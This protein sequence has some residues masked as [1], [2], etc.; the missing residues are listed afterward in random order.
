[1]RIPEMIKHLDIPRSS[2]FINRKIERLLNKQGQVEGITIDKNGRY[3]LDLEIIDHHTFQD[4]IQPKPVL[5]GTQAKTYR[6]YQCDTIIFKRL[7]DYN[8]YKLYAHIRPNIPVTYFP[9]WKHKYNNIQSEI[10][11]HYPNGWVK[12]VGVKERSERDEKYNN[13][14]MHVVINSNLDLS[15]LRSII[16]KSFPESLF[17]LKMDRYNSCGDNNH[18]KEHNNIK[19]SLKHGMLTHHQN[20][21]NQSAHT[22]ILDYY[23]QDGKYFYNTYS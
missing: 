15:D 1:M 11:K 13:F 23:N 9:F 4:L 21:Y 20:R 5:T 10:N 18:S 7:L 8:D 6:D 2:K 19:Y 16:E 17:N 3:Y 22:D 12:V 14:H